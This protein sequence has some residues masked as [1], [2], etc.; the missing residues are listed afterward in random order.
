M[1][2]SLSQVLPGFGP[3]QPGRPGIPGQGPGR[4]GRGQAMRNKKRKQRKRRR[5]IVVLLVTVLVVGAGVAGAYVG[6][7]P[8]VQKLTEPDDYV[9]AGTAEVTV[10]IPKGASGR[11]I[12]GLLASA[13][14][15]KTQQS[16]LD[17]WNADAEASGKVQPGTYTLKKQ[18]SSVS[19]LALMLSS[20]SRSTLS[21]TIP[22]GY[23]AEEI[24]VAL[25][26]KL[27]LSRAA[28]RRAV[29]EGDIGLPKAAGGQAEG[30]LFPATYTFEP[31]VTETEVLTAM[32]TRAKQ[33][34]AAAGVTGTQM[35]E[36][37]IKASLIQ[38]EA[39]KK[40]D[41]APISR[42]LVNRLRIDMPLQLD[43]TISYLTNRFDV[44]TT[45]ADRQTRSPYNTY[46][47][48]GLPAGP[49]TNPGEDA[50]QAA[51][52]PRPGP[53]LYFVAVNPDKKLTKFAVTPAQH[54][55]N[56]EE[57]RAWL[58]SK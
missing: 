32:T 35:R 13:G 14:V 20:E 29:R 21:V 43:T 56:V 27:G 38:A 6:L 22:E 51:L 46:L 18:M 15:V 33:A 45:P 34:Y 31:G 11:T 9:G 19:A 4:P 16:F 25:V 30:F 53:W 40:S 44:T 1:T 36:V 3:S 47:Y 8:L 23:R 10:K 57:F 41:M 28:L 52:H 37:A 49:I 24:Y 58:A 42:V 17:A 50:I 12:A 48:K 26:Q 2:D 54:A 7:A 55:A 5:S 39:G